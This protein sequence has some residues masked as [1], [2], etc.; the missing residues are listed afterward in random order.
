VCASNSASAGVDPACRRP[1]P[2]GV[3]ESADVVLAGPE[4]FRESTVGEAVPLHPVEEGRETR[5]DRDAASF[6][7]ASEFA[8][9]SP[10]IAMICRMFSRNHGIDPGRLPDFLD[11][12]SVSNRLSD[13]ERRGSWACAVFRWIVFRRAAGFGG[14]VE[15]SSLEAVHCRSRAERIAFCSDLE[16]RPNRHHLPPP[17]HLRTEQIPGLGELLEREPGIFV[18]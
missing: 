4:K 16:G 15:G 14:I 9:I 8:R 2:R 13:V 10:S 1:N 3:P 12:P 5:S 7:N 11:R 17:I 18:T 6:R